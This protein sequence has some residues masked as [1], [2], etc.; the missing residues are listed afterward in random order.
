MVKIIFDE[1]PPLMEVSLQYHFINL[2]PG[3]ENL[4]QKSLKLSFVLEGDVRCSIFSA[5]LYF[6]QIVF[7]QPGSAIGFL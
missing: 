7:G 1:R 4:M 3:Q 5:F 2:L 6:C